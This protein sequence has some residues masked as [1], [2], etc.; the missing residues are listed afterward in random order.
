MA[1]RMRIVVGST[2]VAFAAFVTVPAFLSV[3]GATEPEVA[4][5]PAVP[6]AKGPPELPE[7]ISETEAPAEVAAPQ[8]DAAVPPTPAE[9]EPGAVAEPPTDP[10]AAVPEV[11][12]T[13]EATTEQPAAPVEAPPEPAIDPALLDAVPEVEAAS[14]VSTRP[15]GSRDYASP[16]EHDAAV[17]AAYANRYRPADNPLRLNI[18][19]RVMFANASGQQQVNGRLGGAAVDIGPAW[20]KVGIA[21]TFTGWGGR[22]LL[23]AN[24]GAQMNGMVGG[25]LSLGLGRLALMSHG[26]LDL[27]LGYDI[28]YGVVNQRSDATAILASQGGEQLVATLPQNLLPH[29]PRARIDMGLV[30]ST[31]NRFFHGFG[32]SMGYQALIGSLNGG[33]PTTNMLTLGFSYWMG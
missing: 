8:P 30:G 6:E 4:E 12:A 9:T 31:N 29:G 10:A 32:L 33:L 20:N 17:E 23:P 16:E 5:P 1:F 19:G 7:A 28:Y 18:T 3:A 13:P 25:G 15:A 27:R 24:T 22:I 14:P 11:A 2:L 21:A 26:Y